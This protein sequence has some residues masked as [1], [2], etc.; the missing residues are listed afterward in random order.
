MIDV[1]EAAK[2]AAECFAD[3]YSN[4]NYTN[5]LL[6]EVEYDEDKQIWQITLGYS[7]PSAATVLNI[8]LTNL[9]RYKL[10][11]IDAKTGQFLSM[12]IRSTEHA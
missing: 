10:F 11:N 6:E 2:I 8:P 1:K 5:V 7:E 3:F 12:K 9:R 4:Q